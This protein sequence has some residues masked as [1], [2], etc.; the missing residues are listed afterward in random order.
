L[1]LVLGERDARETDRYEPCGSVSPPLH[2]QNETSAI[3]EQLRSKY[4]ATRALE[5]Q[6][7]KI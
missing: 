5:K 2:V 4:E 1:G 3:V 7:A 6:L